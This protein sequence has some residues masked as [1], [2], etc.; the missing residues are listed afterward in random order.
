MGKKKNKNNSEHI[1]DDDPEWLK[2]WDTERG[3]TKDDDL[4]FVNPPP[5][6]HGGVNPTPWWQREP[7]LSEKI[8][9]IVN[10]YQVGDTITDA[11][12]RKFAPL[13][14][15]AF[16]VEVIKG[17]EWG[18]HW[19]DKPAVR[20]ASEGKLKKA[21]VQAKLI[22]ALSS[23]T[24][25]KQPNIK[26]R[27]EFVTLAK[28][29]WAEIIKDRHDWERENAKRTKPEGLHRAPVVD[30][31]LSFQGD[32]G[33]AMPDKWRDKIEANE[34][35]VNRLTEIMDER[36][37]FYHTINPMRGRVILSN[38]YDKV[39]RDQ[40]ANDNTKLKAIHDMLVE[41]GGSLNDVFQTRKDDTDAIDADGYPTLN[42][43][44]YPAQYDKDTREKIR[45]LMFNVV[46][47]SF[48]S[49]DKAEEHWVK[50]MHLSLD[51]LN[52]NS[53]RL[54]K[55][56]STQ[57][58]QNI[59]RDVWRDG[60]SHILKG[61]ELDENNPMC[62]GGLS[63][64]IERDRRER[65]KAK[66]KQGT[67]AKK[68]VKGKGKGGKLGDDVFGKNA[69]GAEGEQMRFNL[70]ARE[71][72]KQQVVNVVRDVFMQNYQR[73]FSGGHRV[74][75]LGV[76]QAYKHRLDKFNL[77]RRKTV[78]DTVKYH[79]TILVDT[80][81]STYTVNATY[82][83]ALGQSIVKGSQVIAQELAVM[84]AV[85]EGFKEAD[86][87]L[88]SRFTLIPFGSFPVE[89]SWNVNADQAIQA[90]NNSDVY[91]G[92]GTDIVQALQAAQAGLTPNIQNIVFILTDGEDDGVETM[93]KEIVKDTQGK[94]H[95]FV[96]GDN[97]YRNGL[98]TFGEVN[99]TLIGDE[100]EFGI[101]F[102][103][104]IKKMINV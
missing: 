75:A 71:R 10:P 53:H 91:T 101:R 94:A 41:K 86:P 39:N 31:G 22:A 60:L 78:I 45:A 17:D 9:D 25:G 65:A 72:M 33:E 46:V 96:F 62:G 57:G 20:Y 30:W 36:R 54:G 1:R 89:V 24:E 90:F 103:E 34:K 84:I 13:L 102:R 98:E 88:S 6:Y 87:A 26:L 14:S 68:A 29:I 2:D 47:A 73:S 77:M 79:F 70:R 21:Q 85:L 43:E 69:G 8:E 27:S 3:Y 92:G 104:T 19:G 44:D 95:A 11:Y 37:T 52:A 49:G 32:K 76:K 80:S 18:K 23:V 15:P 61:V 100:N 5:H 28:E 59:S 4:G 99:V 58:I 48:V 64:D 50:P 83:R 12:F 97:D 40:L 51:T 66:A 16:N 38:A 81:G 82:D 35:F 42:S 74:G 55:V 93:W 67:G 63:D 56:K 7:D